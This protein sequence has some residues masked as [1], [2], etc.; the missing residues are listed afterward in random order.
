MTPNKFGSAY[1]CYAKI[2]SARF[3]TLLS[4]RYLT[5]QSKLL[6][7]RLRNLPQSRRDS[8]LAAE[9][10]LWPREWT[11]LTLRRKLEWLVG[12]GANVV[13]EQAIVNVLQTETSSILDDLFSQEELATAM[14]ELQLQYRNSDLG[15]LRQLKPLS[16]KLKCKPSATDPAQPLKT[17]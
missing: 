9:L 13:P 10:L 11:S 17:I 4:R 2:R 8:F 1:V 16:G 15:R 3:A 5:Y 12:P 14:S 7:K 6:Y